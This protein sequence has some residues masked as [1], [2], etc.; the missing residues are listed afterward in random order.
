MATAPQCGSGGL[1]LG[2]DEL[3]LALASTDAWVARLVCQAFRDRCERRDVSVGSAVQSVA[4][5]ELALAL[6]IPRVDVCES[7]ARGGHLATLQ[8]ARAN[9]CD[10]GLFACEAA[11]SGGHLDV[12]QWA[13]ANGCEWD[14][15]TCY[16]AAAGG[17]L[18]VLQWARANGC[19]WGW[20]TWHYSA[21]YPA[22]RA[23]LEANGCPRD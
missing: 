7:A 5:L 22:V 18:E 12:L 9:G 8:W 16:R 2:S 17:H 4:R 15:W 19:V 14:Q 10:W 23:W 21:R 20:P 13:H 6:G 3:E 11:A 1:P